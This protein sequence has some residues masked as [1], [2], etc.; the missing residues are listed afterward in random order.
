MNRDQLERLLHYIDRAI[1]IGHA[2]QGG[3]PGGVFS[4]QGGSSRDA[5][6]EHE[7]NML[8]QAFNDAERGVI[9]EGEFTRIG[10]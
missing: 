1:A 3:G 4:N 10:D 5:E 7:K 8:R 9:I 2:P 6:L